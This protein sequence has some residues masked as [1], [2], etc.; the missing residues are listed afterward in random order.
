MKKFV[1]ITVFLIGL[2]LILLPI[3]APIYLAIHYNNAVFY[4]LL[5][6]VPILLALLQKG[7][8]KL[9]DKINKK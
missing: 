6:L 3:V 5:L 8:V 1:I 4:L 7:I 9:K 2:S